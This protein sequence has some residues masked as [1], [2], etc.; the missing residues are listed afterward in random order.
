[1]DGS[2]SL[3]GGLQFSH[4]PDYQK[5]EPASSRK[6]GPKPGELVGLI[7]EEFS[8]G[9][10]NWDVVIGA[11]FDLKSMGYEVDVDH[12]LNSKVFESAGDGEV[13][14][15]LREISGA[16]KSDQVTLGA[17]KVY[18]DEHVVIYGRPNSVLEV[19]RDSGSSGSL[20]ELASESAPDGK[21]FERLFLE[22]PD[23]FQRKLVAHLL[24]SKVSEDLGG[25]PRQWMADVFSAVVT[26]FLST[27]VADK[28]SSE[29]RERLKSFL[30]DMKRDSQRILEFDAAAEAFRA[31]GVMP[32]ADEVV[33]R[34]AEAEYFSILD[35]KNG[36]SR[37]FE[38]GW[39]DVP[40]EL[41]DGVSH[42]SHSTR[43]YFE[44]TLQDGVDGFFVRFFD[45]AGGSDQENAYFVARENFTSQGE[46]GGLFV[47]QSLFNAMV[48][49]VD[50]N[51][52]IHDILD[53]YIQGL[54]A[55]N[56]DGELVV[57]DPQSGGY[58]TAQSKIHLLKGLL[59]NEFGVLEGF[60]GEKLR[61]VVDTMGP[62]FDV[63][64]AELDMLASSSGA[65]RTTRR[66]SPSGEDSLF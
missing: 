32:K 27:E 8:W 62:Q 46:H 52:S 65:S 56:Y 5:P 6:S 55:E 28:M 51:S 35:L 13:E 40:G 66:S 11:V 9:S 2:V 23:E 42:V 57:S 48:Y 64:R 58:C 14:A 49:S 53:Q 54:G 7:H 12:I 24:D 33:S 4:P 25:F 59:R 26:D 41:E 44:R 16:N 47:L 37:S 20:F 21:A 19:S 10:P 18:G 63:F 50:G 22:F 61:G 1:M 3:G 15:L 38:S 45:P 39:R 60:L 31:D 17:Q 36:Q 30:A 43:L 29:M 34:Q